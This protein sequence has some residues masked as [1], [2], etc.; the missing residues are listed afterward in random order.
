MRNRNMKFHRVLVD[1][2]ARLAADIVAPPF[3][4]ES[5]CYRLLH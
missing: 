1:K 4:E 2:L 5:G 3:R